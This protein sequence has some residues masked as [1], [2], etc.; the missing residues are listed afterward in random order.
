MTLSFRIFWKSVSQFSTYD[1]YLLQ[2]LLIWH[3]LHQMYI[4]I[5]TAN[6]NYNSLSH[7]L[8]CW[9]IIINKLYEQLNMLQ[10]SRLS[11]L[12]NKKDPSVKSNQVFVF[13]SRIFCIFRLGFL[14]YF[15]CLS[16]QPVTWPTRT[17]VNPYPGRSS[18]TRND[19]VNS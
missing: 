16:S 5:W 12:N 1:W 15:V 19:E 3:Y 18:R 4:H 11:A 13:S 7:V 6:L 14:F 10:Y 2:I 17:Q 9:I 8:V